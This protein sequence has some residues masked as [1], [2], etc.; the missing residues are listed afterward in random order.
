MFSISPFDLYRFHLAK[1]SNLK[2]F[3]RPACSPL[4]LGLIFLIAYYLLTLVIASG[5]HSYLIRVSNIFGPLAL[6]FLVVRAAYSMV[7]RYPMTIW[8]PIVLYFF[9]SALFFGF[10]P[11]V[12]IFGNQETQYYL[13]NNT[14]TSL[15]P[16]ELLRTNLLNAVGILSAS[17]T[18]YVLSGV[19]PFRGSFVKFGNLKQ[20]PNLSLTTVAIFFLITGTALR[21]FFI[22]PYEFGLTTFVLPGVIQNLGH[23][24]DLGLT[25]VAYLACKQQGPWT[26]I[27]L[28][29]LPIHALSILLEFSKTSLIIA[30]L[31]P[32]LGAYLANSKFR[33]LAIRILVI[34][35]LYYLSQPFVHYGRDVIQA[36]TGYINQA[37]IQRRYQIT[38]DF[39]AQGNT[40]TALE[41][42]SEQSGWTRL[43]YS[44]PQSI[45]M[46]EYDSGRPGSTLKNIWIV[47]VPRIVWPN[48]PVGIGPGKEFYKLVRGHE[49]EVLVGVSV[50]GDAY[51]QGGWLGLIILSSLMGVI[52]LFM[53]KLSLNWLFQREL[54]FFPAIFIAV[55]MSLEGT[56][57]FFINK[58]FGALPIYFGYIIGVKLFLKF[59]FFRT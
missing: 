43:A 21:F 54:I 6:S 31:L 50:Y 57:G 38:K 52:F 20:S 58:I 51:W 17:F 14:F 45:V 23:L 49:R 25:I 3:V 2:Y 53:A 5:K 12:Y 47:F 42:D 28:T 16:T 18:M 59:R 22:L 30:L 4:I 40:F 39:F 35:F 46:K 10:G 8:T 48:K 7:R 36:D 41:K 44:G 29:I 26:I 56:T 32:S 1:S 9:S 55:R 33:Q 24:L 37:T 27:L 11:L 34:M 15:T 19:K 13:N